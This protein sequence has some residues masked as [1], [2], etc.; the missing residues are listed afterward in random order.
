MRQLLALPRI[1]AVAAALVI[2]AT[3]LTVTSGVAAADPAQT[4]REQTRDRLAATIAPGMVAELGR[5]F[6][7]TADQVLDRL[8]TEK[9]AMTAQPGVALALDKTYGG[10]W[11]GDGTSTV[12]VAVTTPAAFGKV[13]ALGYT[14]TLVTYAQKTLTGYQRLLDDS[15]A[16]AGVTGWHV[17]IT[18]NKVV[19]LARQRATGDA[20]AWAVKLGVPA[21]ALRVEVAGETPRPFADIV[22]GTAY[23][24]NTSSRCSVGFSVVH[25]SRGDGFVSAGHCGSTGASVTSG[26]GSPGTFV[27]SSF[28]GNDYSYIDAGAG[29]TASPRV[30]GN[31]QEV[32]DANVAPVGS[33]I[34]R[35]GSTTGYHCGS[36]QQL[37]TSVTYPQGTVSGVTRTN[38]CA[39][40]GD[41]GGSFISGASA[42]GMT[43]GGSGN[44]S[45]G[46]TT[47]FQPVGEALSASG[48][49]L[50]TSGSGPGPG[51]GTC[52]THPNNY[53]GSLSGTGQQAYQPNN[54]YYQS[55]VSGTHSA[56][57]QGPSGTDFDL[58]LQKWNGSAWTDVA[59]SDSSSSQ[60]TISYS[61]TAGYYRYRVYSYSGGGAYALGLTKP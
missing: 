48:A 53:S 10:L 60:E 20:R 27:L 3:A 47:Y 9:L 2:G 19:V 14:P 61:G 52:G 45:S 1:A 4:L 34:C 40:P 54:S 49:T 44:C 12:Y 57:L 30:Q 7:F 43:S 35:S 58:Y 6:G 41:S 24:I 22:G 15:S 25:P 59:T 26:T 5:T 46:G 21:N 13:E 56:C 38:V 18:S 23:Y 50:K 42:Q 28:P 16:P 11:I 33:S 32:A 51:P 37:N 29:W 8:T 55:T 31:S 39:E 36:V 17:D